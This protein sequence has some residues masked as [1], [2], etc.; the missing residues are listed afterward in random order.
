[1][2]SFFALLLILASAF[3]QQPEVPTFKA[4]TSL[5]IV[6]VV[7]RDSAGKFVPGLGKSDFT[8]N[9]NGVP[10]KLESVELSAAPS[11]QSQPVFGFSGRRDGALTNSANFAKNA[12]DTLVLFDEIN[13]AFEDQ[14]RLVASISAGPEKAMS[15]ERAASALD[16]HFSV[17]TTGYVSM[18]DLRFRRTM[19]ALHTASIKVVVRNAASGRIGTVEFPVER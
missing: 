7:V 3:A 1:M 12:P 5:V 16:K 4:S 15:L 19:F 2:R 6:D 10:Q 13:T 14:L 18:D 9:E 17:G 11:I 8:V